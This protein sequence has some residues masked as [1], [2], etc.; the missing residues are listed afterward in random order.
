MGLTTEPFFVWHLNPLKPA[1]LSA[2]GLNE[3]ILHSAPLGRK[4]ISVDLFYIV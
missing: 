4:R 2:E 1:G 3:E